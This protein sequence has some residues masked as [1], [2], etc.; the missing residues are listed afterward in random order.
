[1][2]GEKNGFSITAIPEKEVEQMRGKIHE[3][4]T[5]LDKA[6]QAG[7]RDGEEAIALRMTVENL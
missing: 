4:K 6:L 1:M 7:R 5:E 3:L 2:L